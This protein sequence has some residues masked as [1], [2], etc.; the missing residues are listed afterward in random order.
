MAIASLIISAAGFILSFVFGFPVSYIFGPPIGTGFGIGAVILGA[1][2]FKSAKT[3]LS[4]I[5]L[6]VSL[7]LLVISVIRIFSL[8]SC[9]GRISSCLGY[10][11]GGF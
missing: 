10:L 11:T 8:V 9:A 5:A 2:A 1:I 7:I 4:K 3:N 6:I